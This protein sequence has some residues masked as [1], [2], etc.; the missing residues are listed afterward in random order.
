MGV[1]AEIAQHVL[2][3]PKG[4]LEYTIQSWRNNKRSQDAKIRGSASGAS[5]PWNWSRLG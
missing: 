2:G 5:W 4:G 1:G 3:P